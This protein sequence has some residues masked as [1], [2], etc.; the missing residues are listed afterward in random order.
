MEFYTPWK[1][2]TVCDLDRFDLG[3]RVVYVAQDRTCVFVA[4]CYDAAVHTAHRASE[5]EMQGLW[6]EYRL[7]ALLPV[8]RTIH[9]ARR[10]V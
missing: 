9:S 10:P 5:Q 7:V 2:Y 3:N 6:I 8:F 1:N 4:D